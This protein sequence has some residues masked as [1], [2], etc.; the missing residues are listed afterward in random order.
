MTASLTASLRGSEDDDLTSVPSPPPSPPPPPLHATASASS[1]ASETSESLVLESGTSAERSASAGRADSGSTRSSVPRTNAFLSAGRAEWRA[2]RAKER[3]LEE[4]YRRCSPVVLASVRVCVSL[5][6]IAAFGCGVALAA[7]GN[8]PESLG[9]GI[10]GAVLSL[11]GF[12]LAVWCLT[13]GLELACCIVSLFALSSMVVVLVAKFPSADFTTR[14]LAISA[15]AVFF[16]CTCGA[17]LLMWLFD[18]VHDQE[19]TSAF[20]YTGLIP[21]VGR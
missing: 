18:K 19:Y 11:C 17:L 7:V 16:S 15:F 10:A 4:R 5:A 2:T 6:F 13:P 21:S 12:G 20:E 9:L 1:S 14:A 3:A 8:V